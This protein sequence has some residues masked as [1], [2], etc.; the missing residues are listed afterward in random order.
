MKFLFTLQRLHFPLYG[1]AQASQ[2]MISGQSWRG[3]VEEMMSVARNEMSMSE[4]R[5]FMV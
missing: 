4:V 2:P 1:Y 5:W 3:G